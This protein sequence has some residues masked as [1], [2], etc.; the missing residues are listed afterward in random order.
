[1]TDT[2]LQQKRLIAAVIDIAISIVVGV[3]TGIGMWVMA[4]VAARGEGSG[5]AMMIVSH[6]LGFVGALVGL[7]YI[8]LRDILAGDRSLGKKLMNI[9]V[10]AG[11]GSI[12]MMDSIKRNAIFAIGSVLGLL[13]ATLLLIPCLGA[14]VSCLLTPLFLLGWLVGLVAVVVELV[15]VVTD[16]AG[17]R[18]GDQFAGTRVVR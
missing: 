7:A 6:I 1:M 8:L 11:N 15:K 18:F 4:M 17:V 16:P 12:T 2:E 14:M 13:Q 5:T 9:R 3:V 10:V